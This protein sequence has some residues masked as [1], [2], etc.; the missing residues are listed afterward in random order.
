MRVKGKKLNFISQVSRDGKEL[1]PVTNEDLK[2]SQEDKF[3]IHCLSISKQTYI[4]IEF[5]T[6]IVKFKNPKVKKQ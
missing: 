2:H 3:K 4:A 1:I 6:Y 5:N